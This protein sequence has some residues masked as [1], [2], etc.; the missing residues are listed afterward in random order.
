MNRIPIG[1]AL[2]AIMASLSLVA[3]ALGTESTPIT[4]TVDTVSGSDPFVATGGVVC[5][6]GIVENDWVN[7]VGWQNGKGAQIQIVKRFDCGADEFDLLLRVSLDFATCD[8]VG[9]WSVLDGIGRY[10]T[11]RGSGTITGTSDCGNGIR[12]VYTGSMHMN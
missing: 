3:P 7:F 1:A 11:L 10:A 8:T 6:T 2:L 5:A 4:I 9:S 12:D